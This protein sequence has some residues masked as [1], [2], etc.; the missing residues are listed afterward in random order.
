MYHLLFLLNNLAFSLFN[1]LF[2]TCLL[3][4]NFFPLA[5]AISTLTFPFEKYNLVGISVRPS[6][7]IL[8]ISLFISFFLSKSFYH[9]LDHDYYKRID[10]IKVYV[11]LLKTFRHCYLRHMSQLYFLSRLLEI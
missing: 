4:Y 2:F 1:L 10:D 7:L 9:L 11:N 5:T 6:W 8:P 3:S